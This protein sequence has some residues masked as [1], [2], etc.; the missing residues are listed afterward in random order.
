MVWWVAGGSDRQAVRRE[1]RR[2]FSKPMSGAGA[3]WGTNALSGNLFTTP[4]REP[5]S[6]T[7]VQERLRV[8]HELGL[9]K[10]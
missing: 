9:P 6:A 5:T 10:F 7:R 2:V 4:S 1:Q 3:F 8:A